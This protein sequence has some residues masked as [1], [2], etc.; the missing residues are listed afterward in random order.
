MTQSIREV[1]TKDP[2][3]LSQDSTVIEAAKAMRDADVGPALITDKS[4]GLH[5]IVTDRDIAVR[6]VAEG[7][8]PSVTKLGE[9]ASTGLATLTPDDSVDAA[10]KII[11]EKKVR[12]IPVIENDRPVGIVAIG[13]LALARDERSALADLSGAPP[14]N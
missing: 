1:M 11:R 7:L 13:D 2:I 8:D 14:N 3:T 4:G 5:G 9:V 6:V 10:V 12:R